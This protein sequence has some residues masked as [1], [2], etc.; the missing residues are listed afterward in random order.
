MTAQIQI[1][2]YIFHLILN[3]QCQQLETIQLQNQPKPSLYQPNTK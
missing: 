1:I 2:R 3:L